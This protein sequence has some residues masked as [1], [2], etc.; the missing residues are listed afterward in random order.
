MDSI[1]L[2]ITI[3]APLEMVWDCFTDRDHIEEWYYASDQWHCPNAEN[4]F[5]VGGKF[6]YRMEA[7]DESFGFN[8]MGTFD[9][10]TPQKEIKYHLDDG[11][12]VIVTFTEVD[13]N[14][15]SMVQDFE[16]EKKNLRDTQRDGW[17]AV[18]N[19]FQKYVEHLKIES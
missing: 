5:V 1:K 13:A 2:D 8:F 15:V 3:L 12:K 10:I 16:L 17:Y 14:T 7:K 19:N 4:N 18:M 6:N 9:E 11:R